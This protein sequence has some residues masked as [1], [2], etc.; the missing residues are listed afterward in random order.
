[1]PKSKKPST[2]NYEKVRQTILKEKKLTDHDH[3]YLSMIC[4]KIGHP[5]GIACPRVLLTKEGKNIVGECI[6][7]ISKRV[8]EKIP[9][10][11]VQFVNLFDD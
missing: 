9:N 6:L 11:K 1:M 3:T 10:A 2:P 5:D 4:D 8:E 7:S